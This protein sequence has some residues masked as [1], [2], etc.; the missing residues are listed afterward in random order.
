MIGWGVVGGGR[1]DGGVGEWW[2]RGR[3]DGMGGRD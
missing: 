2:G 1:D 3:S